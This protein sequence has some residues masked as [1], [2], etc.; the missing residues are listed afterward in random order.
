MQE[1]VWLSE[2]LVQNSLSAPKS[3]VTRSVEIFIFLGMGRWG[4]RVVQTDISEILE[5]GHSRNFAPTILKAKLALASQIVFHT[6]R[7]LKSSS[8]DRIRIRY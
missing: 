7:R 4:G 1:Q 6:L 5:W 2:L 3:Q 8:C